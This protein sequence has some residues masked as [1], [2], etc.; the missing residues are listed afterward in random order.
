M[1]E[2]S[3]AGTG[4]EKIVPFSFKSRLFIHL[5]NC[6]WTCFKNWLDYTWCPMKDIITIIY[7]RD[8]D[9]I[10]PKIERVQTHQREIREVEASSQWTVLHYF[11]P[12]RTTAYWMSGQ[13]SFFYM[14]L[15]SFHCC[16]EKNSLHLTVVVLVFHGQLLHRSINWS[17]I[18]C[19]FWVGRMFD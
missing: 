13:V 9:S 16:W 17:I 19:Q 10:I 14:L 8:T 1:V 18:N 15:C 3:I 6:V 11:H 5:E 4:I 7:H 12:S 2:G